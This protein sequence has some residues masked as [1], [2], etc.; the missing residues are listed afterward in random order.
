MLKK[1]TLILLFLSAIASSFSQNEF[2]LPS[3]EKDKIRFDLVGNLIIIPVELNGVELS[4]VLDSGVSKP[5]LFNL[6]HV[7]SLQINKVETILIRGLG[8][9]EPIEAIRSK[10]NFLRVGDAIN[11]NQDI[12]M[13]FDNSIN[14]TPRLGRPVHGIIGY[15]LFKNFIV[16]INYASKY[17][18]LHRPDT[19]KY[20][21]CKR[22][23]TFNLSFY[24]NKPYVTGEI[25]VDSTFIPLNLL[26]DTGSSDAL[27]I[28]ENEDKG[29]VPTENMYF[30]DFLGKGLSG[31]IYGKRSKIEKFKLKSFVLNN[32]NTAF[33]DSTSISFA[34][35]N[36]K[37]S[38]SVSGEVLKRFNIIVDYKNRKLTL[39]KNK[40]FKS[41]FSYNKSG[42]II[43]QNGVM[44]VKERK[45]RSGL[46]FNDKS[47]SNIH[48]E[49]VTHY[50]LSVKPAYTIVEIREDS[51]AEKAGLLK[52]DIIVTINNKE[53]HLLKLQN[54]I[55]YFKSKTGK[56]I[57]LK[58]NRNGEM[59]LFTFRLEDVFKQKELP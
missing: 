42:I 52:G 5:I 15:D 39:K 44:I 25:E 14:F 49:T 38:G 32:V 4:F 26:I 48:V 18:V 20:K 22:C 16:E 8:G 21:S 6:A 1:N 37:R 43:E 30:E 29:L 17:I 51:P 35:K 34:R 3:L 9:G 55:G 31:N 12:Y 41:A 23:E 28:F 45:N 57:N 58:I 11:I 33:P 27:W 50:K 7:D 24:K 2:S 53:T 59:M 19:Y 36:I 56:L 46:G 40:N 54:V 10:Q 47:D 13:V